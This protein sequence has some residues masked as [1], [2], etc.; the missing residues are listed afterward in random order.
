[1]PGWRER[2]V[3]GPTTALMRS[4]PRRAPTPRSPVR[5]LDITRVRAA[6]LCTARRSTPPSKPVPLRSMPVCL[7]LGIRLHPPHQSHYRA[8]ITSACMHRAVQWLCSARWDAA[9]ALHTAASFPCRSLPRPWASWVVL[10]CCRCA[11]E[12]GGGP[13][14]PAGSLT[15]SLQGRRQCGCSMEGRRR[16]TGTCCRHPCRQPAGSRCPLDSWVRPC[17]ARLALPVLAS[18]CP[19]FNSAHVLQALLS[20]MGVRLNSLCTMR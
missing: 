3:A 1:M 8:H 5:L 19:A 9:V 7:K 17:G 4:H 16:C 18:P 11:P 2:G 10:G 15:R 12:P 6:F 13:N 20:C 14:W